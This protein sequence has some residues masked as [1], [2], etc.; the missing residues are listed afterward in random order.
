MEQVKLLN[1]KRVI[2][3]F[4]YSDIVLARHT[5]RG[6][7]PTTVSGQRKLVVTNKRVILTSDSHGKF[8]KRTINI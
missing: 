4:D 6:V 5:R 8:T 3:S 1:N 2:K 7:M